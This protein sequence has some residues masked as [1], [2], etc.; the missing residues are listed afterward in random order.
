M[1]SAGKKGVGEEQEKRENTKER[2]CPPAS[3]PLDVC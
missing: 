2:W 3:S 1:V